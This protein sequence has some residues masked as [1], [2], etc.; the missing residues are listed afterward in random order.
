MPD[1]GWLACGAGAT[2]AGAFQDWNTPSNIVSSNNSYADATLLPGA[3]TDYLAATQ[4]GASFTSSGIAGI[5]VRL[6][7][8][9]DNQHSY[10]VYLTKDGSA[11][12]GNPSTGTIVGVEEQVTLG[13]ASDLWGTTWSESEVEASTFGVLIRAADTLETSG[14]SYVDFVEVRITYNTP[15]DPNQYLRMPTRMW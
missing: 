5:E 13:G 12:V 6:E 14:T 9:T 8:Y 7:W 1:T 3:Q 11:T 10:T 15:P 4:F 2:I